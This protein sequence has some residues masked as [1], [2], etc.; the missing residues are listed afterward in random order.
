MP[1]SCTSWKTPT[2]LA[3]GRLLRDAEVRC[4]LRPRQA[5]DASATH[6]R[7]LLAFGHPASLRRDLQPT[8]WIIAVSSVE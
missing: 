4:D 5:G 7:F 2:V 6:R 3:V 1:V 8:P